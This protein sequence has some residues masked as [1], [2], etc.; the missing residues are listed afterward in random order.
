MIKEIVFM[1]SRQAGCTGLLT[2][3]AAGHKVTGIIAYEE[4]LGRLSRELDVPRFSSV[5]QPEILELLERGDLLVSVH[6]KEIVPIELLNLPRLG[7]INV[8]P[9][10]YAYKGAN[11]IERLLNDGNTK[12]SIGVHRMIEKVDQGEVL[13]EEFVDVTGK[14]SIEEVY[15]ALYPYYSLTLLKAL[16]ILEAYDG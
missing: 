6:G 8:H 7:C 13:V 14:Q 10:L 3:L 9:C 16:Q 15:N 11:P 1:G 5:L 4:I 2:L 12:A